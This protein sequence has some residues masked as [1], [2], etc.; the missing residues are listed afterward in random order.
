LGSAIKASIVYDDELEIRQRLLDDTLDGLCYVLLAIV[1]G[2]HDANAWCQP[3][4]V[5]LRD[6][7]RCSTAGSQKFCRITQ[8]PP[9]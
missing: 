4:A 5:P 3:R 8:S 6:A 2:E 9:N 7:F 1:Y